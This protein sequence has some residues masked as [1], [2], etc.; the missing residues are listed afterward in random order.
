MKK[1]PCLESHL[2]RIAY[3]VAGEGDSC[4]NFQ[5][6]KIL[7][8]HIGLT[9]FLV[10][11]LLSGAAI[12][13]ILEREKDW[14]LLEGKAQRIVGMY[15]EIAGTLQK[16]CRLRGEDSGWKKQLYSSLGALSSA[17]EARS[18]SIDPSQSPNLADLIKPRW[19]YI[20]AVLYALSILTTTGKYK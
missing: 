20:E 4:K 5:V 14:V 16:T 17:H 10:G 8:P 1:L 3:E 12:F 19:N 11:Y 15:E 7:L 6:A 9:V 18:F 2:M 13:Q